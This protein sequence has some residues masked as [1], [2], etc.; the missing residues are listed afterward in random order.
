[1]LS[2]RDVSQVNGWESEGIYD[3]QQGGVKSH[4]HWLL[5]VIHG[6]NIVNCKKKQQLWIY[7]KLRDMDRTCK[8]TWRAEFCPR[9]LNWVTCALQLCIYTYIYMYIYIHIHIHVY[10][11]THVHIYAYTHINIHIYKHTYIKLIDSHINSSYL[12]RIHLFTLCLQDGGAAVPHVWPDGHLLLHR[13]LLFPLVGHELGGDRS[14]AG[15]QW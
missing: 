5:L 14:S 9:A 8:M 10:I 2:H 11:Y 3:L 12:F 6:T 1:M 4:F 15:Q 7:Q 13:R